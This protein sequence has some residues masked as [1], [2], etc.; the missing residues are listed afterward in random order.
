MLS[1]SRLFD[2][3]WLVEQELDS[4]KTRV[5]LPLSERAALWRRGFTSPNGVLYDFETYDPRAYLSELQ[6]YRL[7]RA[8]NGDHRYLVDDK[9]SQHWMLSEH[10]RHRPTAF[11]VVDRGYIHEVAGTEF[12]DGSKPVSEWVFPALRRESK[13]VLKQLRGLG[14]KEVIV[15]EGD[16]GY[17]IDGRPADRGTVR[18]RVAGLSDY[19]VTEYVAQHDYADALYSEAANTIRVLTLWDDRRRELLVPM[20]VQRV[21]TDRSRPVDNWSAGGLSARVERTTG[22]L[23]AAACLSPAGELEWHDEHPD[24]GAPIE[25]VTVPRWDDVLATVERIARENTNIPMIGWDVLVSEDGTP[26]VLEA[27][28]G[29]DLDLMQ[30]HRPLL[31][32]PAVAAVVSRYLP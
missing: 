14:G 20:A 30:V 10:E 2:Y 11:G 3:K 7:Y 9:L 19:L 8:L 17:S 29:T 27:N 15:L 1:S 31:D 16:D 26:V 4:W 25:G 23:T 6:R 28:T 22:R 13:L 12:D 18:K 32:D 24:T 5:E 21:G